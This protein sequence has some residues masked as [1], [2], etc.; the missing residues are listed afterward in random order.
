[1]NDATALFAA[2]MDLTETGT[3]DRQTLIDI[4]PHHMGVDCSKLNSSCH[5]TLARN[6][7]CRSIERKNS[8]GE[9]KGWKTVYADDPQWDEAVPWNDPS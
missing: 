1:M 3:I 4:L 2:L 8:R 7:L 9:H 6:D 5:E